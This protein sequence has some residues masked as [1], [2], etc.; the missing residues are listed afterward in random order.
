MVSL[1]TI[2]IVDFPIIVICLLLINHIIKDEIKDY[3]IEK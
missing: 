1:L 2:G 3:N